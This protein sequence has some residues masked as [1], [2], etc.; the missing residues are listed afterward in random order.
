M[1]AR[2]NTNLRAENTVDV[3]VRVFA[4]NVF[5]NPVRGSWN[6]ETNQVTV[7]LSQS[8]TF[9]AEINETLGNTGD[10][11]LQPLSRGVSVISLGLCI[12]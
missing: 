3:S 11:L 12:M 4:N 8:V 6:P 7:A 1:L 5:R 10:S 2:G 9:V